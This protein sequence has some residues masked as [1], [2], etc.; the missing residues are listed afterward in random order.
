MVA[1]ACLIFGRDRAR[2][3]G[4]ADPRIGMHVQHVCVH[5]HVS[6]YL[7]HCADLHVCIRDA[8]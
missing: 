6:I 3:Q 2:E 4:N 8:S 7:A 1:F 5:M